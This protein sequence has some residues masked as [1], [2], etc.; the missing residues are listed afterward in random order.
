MISK[1]SEYEKNYK[2]KNY[3][4]HNHVTSGVVGN[5]VSEIQGYLQSP[6]IAVWAHAGHGRDYII[7]GKVGDEVGIVLGN[8]ARG[9]SPIQFSCTSQTGESSHVFLLYGFTGV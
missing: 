8:P 5:S 3:F 6:D 2:T 9:Y 4:V 7:P 1:T